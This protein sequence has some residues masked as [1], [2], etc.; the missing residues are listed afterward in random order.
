MHL[1]PGRLLGIAV[2]WRVCA[3][4]ACAVTVRL[5]SVD[6]LVRLVPSI[7]LCSELFI[8]RHL[9]RQHSLVVAEGVHNGGVD[10]HLHSIYRL[11]GGIAESP[12][13]SAKKKSSPGMMHA[14]QCS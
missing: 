10:R 13:S 9:E 6:R 2:P 3:R 1:A 8:L 11:S 12:Q 14:R 7:A 4:I 5:R